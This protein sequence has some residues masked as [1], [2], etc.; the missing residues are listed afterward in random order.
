MT[1]TTRGSVARKKRKNILKLAKRFIG[2]HSKLYRTA[3]QQVMKSLRYSYGDRRKK[4][5]FYRSLW[6]LRI[7][8]AARSIKTKYNRIINLLKQVK[9]TMNRKVISEIQHEDKTGFHTI[10]DFDQNY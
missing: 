10:A 9:N 2:S 7:N 4:K 1:R 5:I 6:I 3:N 8:A